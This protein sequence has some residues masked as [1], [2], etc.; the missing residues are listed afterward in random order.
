MWY[1]PPTFP[2][3]LLVAL[4]LVALGNIGAAAARNPAPHLARRVL[5]QDKAL[6]LEIRGKSAD[7]APELWLGPARDSASKH[8]LF[9]FERPISS[10]EFTADDR[11]IVVFWGGGALGQLITVFSK[12]SSSEYEMQKVEIETLAWNAFK[13]HNHLPGKAE[14][15]TLYCHRVAVEGSSTLLFYIDGSYAPAG[16][17][18][19]PLAP[20][21]FKYSLEKQRIEIIPKPH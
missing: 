11:Y 5:S 10:A 16:R 6:A 7:W 13:R 15:V 17:R 18:Q 9:D 1:R 14:F 3:I 4:L 19:T 21:Y 12:R 2:A 20:V 8:L